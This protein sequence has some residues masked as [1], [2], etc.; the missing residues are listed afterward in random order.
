MLTFLSDFVF[1]PV[2]AA[3]DL[4]RRSSAVETRVSKALVRA[5]KARESLLAVKARRPLRAD[6]VK[7]LTELDRAIADLRASL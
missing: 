1:A 3:A 6:E 4:F 2:A 7:A 5:A